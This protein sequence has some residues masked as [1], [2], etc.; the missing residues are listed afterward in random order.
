MLKAFFL[1][2]LLSA[3]LRFTALTFDSLWLDESYQTVVESYG[4]PLP[5]LLNSSGKSFI[6]KPGNPASIKMVLQNFRKVDPLCPPLFA[7]LINRWLTI[8]GGSD[9]ALRGFSVLCSLLSITVTYCFGSAFFGK[10]AGLYAALIQAISPFDIAYAQ[11]AR[12]YSLCTLLATISGGSLLYLCRNKK[13]LH[14]KLFAALYAI[15]T[16]ALINSH[17]TQLFFW[18][19]AILLSLTVAIM[20]KDWRLAAHVSIANLCIVLLSIPW[21]PLFLQAASIHTA[22]FYIAREPSFFWPIWALLVRIPF[23]WLVFLSGKKVMLWAVPVYLSSAILIAQVYPCLREY[24]RQIREK[25]KDK[26]SLKD[27]TVNLTIF[28]IFL[29]ATIPAL[30]IWTLDVIETHRIIEISRY[31]ICTAPAIFLLAGYGLS[32]FSPK[33]YVLPFAIAHTSF[34]LANNAYLHIVPQKEPWRE[35]AQV[36]ETVTKQDDLLFVS[37]YYNIAC[38]D[39]YLHNPLRQIGVSAA[40]GALTIEQTLNTNGNSS[41]SISPG[42]WVL[43]AQEGDSIFNTIPKS[44]R[45]TD[46]YDFPH[47]LHLRKYQKLGSK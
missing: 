45:V 11:E 23:N 1:L 30:M 18:A 39:R 25:T 37:N 41:S 35:V 27:P 21:L 2:L 34:C 28:L 47:A 16:W 17:Y 42:F 36:I 4:N 12:M 14:M 29:W 10:R 6:Y 40:T 26:D 3:G 8:F 24:I 22:S 20:R 13:S 46:Q 32:V 19:F 33:R 9:F 15:S 31:I 44:F 43:S 38:L 7:I 5:D